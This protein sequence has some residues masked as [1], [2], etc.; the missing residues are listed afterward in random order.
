[1]RNITQFQ[2]TSAFWGHHFTVLEDILEM[3]NL[4]G[5]ISKVS[6]FF[7]GLVKLIMRYVQRRSLKNKSVRF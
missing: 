3:S 2:L 4:A 7:Q 5:E 1:M 6:K